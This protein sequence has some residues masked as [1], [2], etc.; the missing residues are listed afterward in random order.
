MT[1]IEPTAVPARTIDYAAVHRAAT[2]ER[3]DDPVLVAC[4][5][6]LAGR[7]GDPQGGGDVRV[8]ADPRTVAQVVL[9]ALIGATHGKG[10]TS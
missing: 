5:V 1:G 6:V 10:G 7:W 3:G 9:N 4:A 2:D 8:V